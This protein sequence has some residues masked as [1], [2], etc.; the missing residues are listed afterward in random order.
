MKNRVFR[1]YAIRINRKYPE[2]PKYC[3]QSIVKAI[4]SVEFR[5]FKGNREVY[6]SNITDTLRKKGC[7]V[8]LD[9]KALLQLWLDKTLDAH[10]L[11]TSN[12]LVT[13]IKA[14]LDVDRIQL[15]IPQHLG[16]CIKLADG[17]QR[18]VSKSQWTNILAKCPKCLS[19]RPEH[20]LLC[21]GNREIHF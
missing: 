14:A 12:L 3:G 11:Q 18:I 20:Y 10:V 8:D 7:R 19:P 15:F 9:L 17:S 21:D 16:Y 4:V 13:Q 6:R 5:F 2:S 1:D